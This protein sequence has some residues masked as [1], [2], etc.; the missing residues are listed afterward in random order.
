[1]LHIRLTLIG[2]KK[3]GWA[4]KLSAGPLEKN[5]KLCPST[6]FT[7]YLPCIM[8]GFTSYLP[9]IMAGFTSYLPCIMTE[10]TNLPCI[11]TRFTNYLPCIMTGFTSYLPCIMTV[12]LTELRWSLNHV[13]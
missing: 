1:M 10:F 13:L 5:V 8:T 11:M 3:T 7:S 4:P 9:C 12:T 6:G 2:I